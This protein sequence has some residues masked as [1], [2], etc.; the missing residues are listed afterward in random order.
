MRIGFEITPLT[1]TLTGIGYYVRHLARELA[2]LAAPDTL[3]GFVAGMQSLA[4]KDRPFQYRR[5]LVPPR[6]LHAWWEHTG[7]P[8][9]DRLLPGLNV[10]HAVNYV[11]PPLRQARGVLSIHDVGFLHNAP[12][13]PH[14]AAVPFRRTIRRDAA[15]A[16]AILTCSHATRNEIVTLLEVPPDKVHVTYYA[17]DRS[18]SPVPRDMAMQRLRGALGLDGPYLL[19]VSTLEARKNVAGL[20]EAFS[21]ADVPHRLVLVG[22]AGAGSEAV[23]ARAKAPDLADRVVIAGYL[24]DRS[25]FPALYSA[26]DGLVFPSWHEG[27][28]LAVLE[29]MSCGCPVITSNA[30][31]LPEVG[32]DQ[33]FRGSMRLKGLAQAERFSWRG[34]A[35][36]TLAV[37][38]RLV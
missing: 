34:C 9:M 16:D 7:L 12:W 36:E 30:S 28:G 21:R 5:V 1:Y 13:N 2:D 31:S 27:F 11:L 24:P 15:R 6:L 8:C 14:G 17:A 25:L 10:Y 26:A 4:D 22:L 20:L 33:G 18:F 23:L 32:G 37:Y 35:E 38:R 19:F 29:A 3:H